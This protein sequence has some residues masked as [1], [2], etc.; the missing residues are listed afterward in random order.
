MSMFQWGKRV[1]ED[2]GL[3]EYGERYGGGLEKIS[4]PP[5]PPCRHPGHNPPGHIVLEPGTYRYTCPGCGAS[6]TFTVP[7]IYHQCGNRH[8]GECNG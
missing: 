3:N 7:A 6:V 5:A 8:Q 4:G 1:L 2:R